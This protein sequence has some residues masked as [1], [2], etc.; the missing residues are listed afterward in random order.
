MPKKDSKPMPV[1]ALA[2]IVG[3]TLISFAALPLGQSD[4]PDV[5]GGSNTACQG[6]NHQEKCFSL[7]VADTNKERISGLSGRSGLRI[8]NG[9]LFVFDKPDKQCIWMKDM[10]FSLDIIWLN[11]FKEIIKLEKN[12]SPETFPRTFC[13]GDTKYVMEF[14]AGFADEYGLKTGT[15]L[16][17]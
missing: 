12:V 4:R 8:D 13:S 1:I 9:M 5:N 7:E 15:T 3:L 10:L 6:L 17:F 16:Q 11:E 2:L 14:T